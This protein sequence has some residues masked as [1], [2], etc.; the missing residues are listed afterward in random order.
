MPAWDAAGKPMKNG[1]R[2]SSLPRLRKLNL[3]V[4]PEDRIGEDGC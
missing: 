4:M 1:Q 3:D 2:Q